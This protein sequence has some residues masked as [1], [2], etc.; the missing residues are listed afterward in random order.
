MTNPKP[1]ELPGYKSIVPN[2]VYGKSVASF[3]HPNP[4]IGKTRAAYLIRLVRYKTPSNEDIIEFIR[5]SGKEIGQSPLPL[6]LEE[7][8][9]PSDNGHD[10]SSL[11]RQLPPNELNEIAKGNP[12]SIKHLKDHI[13]KD[14]TRPG[15]EYVEIAY[16]YFP[17]ELLVTSNELMEREGIES[18]R[19][20]VDSMRTKGWIL[21]MK[22]A[23]NGSLPCLS[24]LEYLVQRGVRDSDVLLATGE[25]GDYEIVADQ[26]KLIH[27][28]LCYPETIHQLMDSS[29]VILKRKAAFIITG[30]SMCL[31][32][33][34]KSNGLPGLI[35]GILNGSLMGGKIVGMGMMQI[36]DLETQP[37]EPEDELPKDPFNPGNNWSLN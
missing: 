25:Y 2:E 6:S 11:L 29:H 26:V 10:T 4:I 31:A 8:S 36:G 24:E 20:R 16:G 30:L 12:K 3:K 9:D 33:K 14:N 7:L 34:D 13:P 5:K 23:E 27:A 18:Y 22:L 21:R 28:A 19:K 15:I 17:P 32:C 1:I 35:G 37:S